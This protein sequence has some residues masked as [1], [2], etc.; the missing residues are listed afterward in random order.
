MTPSRYP[1][2]RPRAGKSLNAR[3]NGRRA[4]QPDWSAIGDEQLLEMRMCDL[5]LQIEDTPL[6][7][8]IARLY[9]E[10]AARNLRIRPHCWLS[11]TWF[12]PDGVPGIAIPFY[13]AHPR[14]MRLEKKQMH[15]VEGGTDDWCMRI[16]RHEAGHALDTSFR[17]HRRRHY[18]EVFGRHSLPYPD[19]Y[20]P[21]PL[22]KEYVLNLDR[23]YAQSH[24]VE[25]FAETFAVWLKPRSRW[26]S[27]YQDW[28]AMAK[29]ECVDALVS[30]VQGVA[31]VVRSQRRVE[32]LREIRITLHEHYAE[33]RER[34]GVDHPHFYDGKLE[35]LFAPASRSAQ[36]QPAATF[37]RQIRAELLRVVSDWTGE[38]PYTIDQVLSEMIGRCRQRK[39]YLKRSEEETKRNVLV[40]LTV[41]MMNYAQGGQHRLAV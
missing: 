39:L 12:S 10:L 6:A 40:M 17:L 20:K 11:D 13:L 16:L 32:P 33:K 5:G 29:L 26:R 3:A 36:R 35:R 28:P 30:G 2:G 18:R 24:P 21:R 9:A 14:L 23:W 4:R 7:A 15:E 19:F 1:N 38:Y 41:Q 34:Y 22:S 8:R 25:D 37:L 31:P 27:R